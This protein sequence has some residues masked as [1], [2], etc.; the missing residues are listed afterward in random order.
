MKIGT[1]NSYGLNLSEI[2]KG[3]TRHTDNPSEDFRLKYFRSLFIGIGPSYIRF[4]RK[5]KKLY[6]KAC[7]M[8]QGSGEDEDRAILEEIVIIF[9]DVLD[10][11]HKKLRKL[12][13]EHFLTLYRDTFGREL[14]G[15]ESF[16]YEF[17]EQD[18]TLRVPIKA[19]V[20]HSGLQDEDEGIIPIPG[21]VNSEKE[22]LVRV[23]LL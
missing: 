22:V 4:E 5:A 17:D 16:S 15:I 23:A 14:N 8:V 7:F 6:N 11:L 21:V 3:Y 9:P 2:F 10:P 13:R 12:N 18:L 19:V 1:S 20:M